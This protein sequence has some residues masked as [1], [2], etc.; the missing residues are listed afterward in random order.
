M[1][2]AE[3]EFPAATGEVSNVQFYNV[4]DGPGIRTVVFLKGCPLKCRWCS[5]PETATGGRELELLRTLCNGCGKCLDACPESALSLG[6]DNVI[7]ADRRKCSGCGECLPSCFPGALAIHGRTMTVEEVF[8]EFEKDKMFFG[9][10][11]GATFSGGEPLLQPAF[12][13]RV[14]ELCKQA[15]IHTCLETTGCVNRRAW[16]RVLPVTDEVLYDLK[17]LD[18]E[19]HREGT[20]SSN[21]LILDNARWLAGQNV[22]ITF[23]VPVIPG[24]NDDEE[25]I[26]ALARFVKGLKGKR[27][28]G[29]EL[30]PYHRMGLGKYQ[31]L[32]REYGLEDLEAP[33]AERVEEIR[34]TIIA[35]GV[36]CTISR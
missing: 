24:F 25:N 19:R 26:L 7:Q 31:A 4:H 2:S 13:A 33:G 14:F 23:R 29:I 36:A 9:A 15:K 12:V 22:R 8:A 34:D 10:E 20:G 6:D 35:H 21:T 16:E 28:E 17:H 5:N 30:L 3:P 1:A 18:P 27:I 11:G 32:D